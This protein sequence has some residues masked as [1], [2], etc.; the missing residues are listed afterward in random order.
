MNNYED[1]INNIKET[2]KYLLEMVKEEINRQNSILN[3]NIQEIIKTID[4]NRENNKKYEATLN[5]QVLI[6]ELTE[7]IAKSNDIDEIKAIR[8]KLNYYINKVKTVI[9]ERNISE[10]EYN[11]YYE[12]ATNLRKSIAK[13]I[14]FLKRE[15]NI[16]EIER[17]HNKEDLTDE[18][19]LLLKKKIKLETNYGRRNS[20]VTT[21]KKEEIK[22]ENNDSSLEKLLKQLG[23]SEEKIDRKPLNLNLNIEPKKEIIPTE[24]DIEKFKKSIINHRVNVIGYDNVDSF[25][26]ERTDVFSGRYQI[27][28]NNKYD[29]CLVHNIANFIKNVPNFIH[30]KG[31]IKMMER[32]CSIYDRSP[33]FIG[34][35]E[36]TR[37]SNSIKKNISKL[38]ENSTLRKNEYTYQNEQNRVVKWIKNFCIHNDLE[39]DYIKKLHN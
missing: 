7:Q 5:A 1:K 18:E 27:K 35:I 13:Y 11:K 24:V 32:D 6:K 2:E 17:L 10:E 21:T 29:G 37:Y 34:F 36:Y 38:F 28:K 15:D 16:S 33:E 19:E 31:R 26:L 8:N 4:Y 3:F 30:N 20:N 22:K 25:L 9:K 23:R 14:R 39:I 12:N